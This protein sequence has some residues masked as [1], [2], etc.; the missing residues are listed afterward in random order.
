[1][2]INTITAMRNIARKLSITIVFFAI[3]ANVL[4]CQTDTV[5]QALRNSDIVIGESIIL[6][7]EI[8]GE[9]REIM[10]HVPREFQPDLDTVYYPVMYVFDAGTAFLPVVALMTQLS[11]S[12]ADEICPQMIVVGINH[13]DRNTDLGLELDTNQKISAG[14]LEA[15]KFTAFIEK[16]LMPYIDSH[17]HTIHYRALVGY[18]LGGLKAMHIL[19][20]KP[21]LFNAYIIIDPS[22]GHYDNQWFIRSA[23]NIR[24]VDLNEKS[25]F[26]AMAQTV[27]M[28]TDT[29]AIKLD[30]TTDSRHMRNIM[31]AAENFR[32]NESDF[33][34][35]WKYYPDE[36]HGSVPLIAEY[37]GFYKIFD[38]F[39]LQKIRYIYKSNDS[40]SQVKAAVK[41]H[42][43]TAS[44]QIGMQ[45]LP[46]E[47]YLTNLTFFFYGTGKFD[48]ALAISE[49]LVEYYPNSVN[50]NKIRQ[51]LLYEQESKPKNK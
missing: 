10:I 11:T 47:E 42:F 29:C 24:I 30:T 40:A 38:W 27:K 45:F 21:Y 36:Y 14:S 3:C 32:N 33:D 7:S 49:L 12:M 16:E 41:T 6:H 5:D 19:A 46:P 22:L 28:G 17:Y 23:D 4:I 26:L 31:Q 35:G 48:K 39:N 34:F 51:I 15:D 25:V 13:P 44:Q 9:N 2:E 37:D 1:V 50:A 18:S 8:L 20:Y 43:E